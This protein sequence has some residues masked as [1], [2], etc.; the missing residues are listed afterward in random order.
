[1]GLPGLLASFA[2][3]DC[4]ENNLWYKGKNTGK[5][6]KICILVSLSSITTLVAPE[7]AQF[8]HLSNGDKV[9]LPT[10]QDSY[11]DQ[12]TKW[13]ETPKPEWSRGELCG[14][15]SPNAEFKCQLYHWVTLWPWTCYWLTLCLLSWGSCEVRWV[16]LCSLQNNT[17]LIT[18]SR[19]SFT[20][21]YA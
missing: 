19:E 12:M 10:S 9:P 17:W 14:Y 4:Y 3:P 15:E 16:G 2:L 7:L 8:L 6:I 20:I 18:I 5:G 13:L 1:M 21:I 11:E